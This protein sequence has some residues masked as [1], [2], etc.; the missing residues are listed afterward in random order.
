MVP[1][2]H[3]KTYIL[4]LC[5]FLYGLS[6]T[7]AK[8][9][10][11]SDYN[12]DS[13]S[14]KTSFFAPIF[15]NCPSDIGPINTDQGNCGAIVTWTEPTAASSAGPVTL[16]T[17]G[18]S[19]GDEFLP[20]VTTVIY[21]ATDPNGNSSQ[22]SFTVT[23]IDR[24][25]PT[26]TGPSDIQVSNAPGSCSN[27]VNYPFPQVTDNCP[28]N[29]Q[30]YPIFTDFEVPSRNDLADV[31]WQFSG[32]VVSTSRPIS[33]SS[34]FLT[35]EIITTENRSLVSPLTYLNG[36]GQITFLHNMSSPGDNTRLTV[37][38]ED[39]ITGSL[40]VLFNFTY[41]DTVTRSAIIPVTQTGIFFVR[42]DFRTDR[43]LNSSRRGRI[44]NLN[45]PGIRVA[46]TAFSWA[47][48]A[49]EYQVVQTAGLPSGA[50]F[51]IG[52]TVNTFESTDS[53]GNTG[54]FSFNVT[55]EDNEAPIPDNSTLPDISGECTVTATPPT[56][57]DNC[58]GTITATTTDDVTYATVGDYIITW[59]YDDGN[60]NSIQQ[61]QNISVTDTT[62]PVPDNST[63][64]DISG[65]CTVTAT[66][67]TATDNCSGT[68]TATTTDD[69]SYATVGDYIITWTYDDGNGNSMQ[70]TQN[71][72]VTDTTAPVPDNSTLPDISGECTLNITSPTATD[73]CS[74]RITATTTDPVSYDNAGNFTITWTYD[75]GNGNSIQQ[76]QN[77]IVTCAPPELD[78]AITKSA[79][80]TEAA[81]AD[82]VEFTV[83]VENTSTIAAT[84]ISIEDV[85]PDGFSFI[86]VSASQGSFD[87]V[88]GE[89]TIASLEAG[90]SA[91][92]IMNTR[93][94]D[95]TNYTNIAS[96][97]FL[98]QT[99]TNPNNDRDEVT[100][101]VITPPAS[102]CL[103][104][105][106]EITP[107]NDGVN[108]FF[109]IECIE[110][111]P[112]NF[113][114]IFNR[115]GTKLF[116][117][118]GYLNNW[119][120]TAEKGV[121]VGAGRNLP[122]GTYFYTIDFGDP[123]TPNKSGWIYISR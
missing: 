5:C 45:I 87:E 113:L 104:V 47:C 30:T 10:V 11:I 95:G 21:T 90:S 105:Y 81:V 55:V 67:P 42:F 4:S 98:D 16:T 73:N 85:L 20:G 61:T 15:S 49:L 120:G 70:Q 107:N 69:V 36:T 116:E 1:K 3:L 18:Y 28:A 24:Q 123:N 112:N 89:W 122:A 71:I 53:Y 96:L 106:N 43:K 50:V 14:E 88:I 65:E 34:S 29:D 59:T 17:N 99:D 117:S 77:V 121:N 54:T 8:E 26:I 118:R 94:E 39:P 2:H 64:P 12:L 108:D 33:G 58:S 103:T 37:S 51:P 63:L 72:S 31:C 86:S 97:A 32:S 93:V 82:T 44:D 75:D 101:L 78:L 109:F 57:T 100:I 68:I 111:Y 102:G 7:N 40:T 41:P 115:W 74:G 46:D 62:A 119:A 76:T 35:S 56:A 27:V 9:A 60:G 13:T 52:T 6:Q 110:N 83:T 92:L 38:L 48:P 79:D 80:K 114:Q 91:S 23:V 66:P 84:N 22:C 25:P 19:P